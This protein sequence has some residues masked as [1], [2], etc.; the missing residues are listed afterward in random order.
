MTKKCI[1]DE[2]AGR[3]YLYIRRY[4]EDTGINRLPYPAPGWTSPDI[5]I[6]KPDGE[7]GDEVVPGME[8]QIEVIISN[9]GGIIAKD[10]LVEVFYSGPSSIN[11]NKKISIYF[12]NE[13]LNNLA[14]RN[15]H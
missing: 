8:N 1:E 10:A 11:F 5:S 3:T 6:I 15:N 14:L 13:L 2:F 7:R 12:E 9:N 4:P